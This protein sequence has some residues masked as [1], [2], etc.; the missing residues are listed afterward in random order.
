MKEFKGLYHNEETRIP[1]FEH[2]AHFRYLDLFNALKELKSNLSNK[3]ESQNLEIYNTPNKN[4]ILLIKENNKKPKHYKLKTNLVTE[5]NDNQRYKDLDNIKEY[6]NDEKK[7]NI[8]IRESNKDLLNKS[9]IN[10]KEKG[11]SKSI[12]RVKDRLPKIKSKKN[13]I[14]LRNKSFDP[15]NL[16]E[17]II[18]DFENTKSIDQNIFEIKDYNTRNKNMEINNNKPIET[19][20]SNFKFN[21]LK[22]NQRNNDKGEILPKINSFRY[23]QIQD[24]LEDIKETGSQFQNNKNNRINNSIDAQS[25]KFHLSNRKSFKGLNRF[26]INDSNNKNNVNVLERSEKR[27]PNAIINNR[28][29][30]IFETEKQIKHNNL[31]FNEKNKN[32]NNNY[33]ETINNDIAQQIYKLKKQLLINTKKPKIVNNN[34]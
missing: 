33:F 21:S 18:Y 29:K 4:E 16:V 2:G 6:E 9:K 5:T 25:I 34:I 19:E 22:I 28:L 1:S 27:R 20:V 10:F 12:D 3:N 14:S 7:Y 23:N 32:Y 8:Y 24:N 13:P 26:F 15:Q 11:L 17:R 31:L 30:S